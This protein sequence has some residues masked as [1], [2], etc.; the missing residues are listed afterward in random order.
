MTAPSSPPPSST[1]LVF[2]VPGDPEQHTADLSAQAE[3]RLA[4]SEALAE[5]DRAFSKT[6]EIKAIAQNLVNCIPRLLPGADSCALQLYHEDSG[7][8]TSAAVWG[9]SNDDFPPLLLTIDAGIAGRVV[10][11]RQLI[12]CGYEAGSYEGQ[13]YEAGSYEGQGYKAGSYE[14]G[15]V[16][17]VPVVFDGMVLGVLNVFS[18]RPYAFTPDD[19]RLLSRLALRGALALHHAMFYEKERTQRQTLQAISS[20]TALP[21]LDANGAFDRLLAYVLSIGLAASANIMLIQEGVL[22]V[23]HHNGYEGDAHLR[24]LCISVETYYYY[25]MLCSGRPAWVDDVENDPNWYY[26]NG[27]RQMRIRSW[28]AAPISVA[29]RTIGFINIESP[30]PGAFNALIARRLDLMAVYAALAIENMRLHES[31]LATLQAEQQARNGLKE[32]ER[33]VP[34][35][36]MLSTAIHEINNPLQSI[37]N[38]LYILENAADEAA[39]AGKNGIPLP[40]GFQEARPFFDVAISE[41]ERL[42]S[43]VSRL[44][45]VQKSGFAN[46]MRRLTVDLGITVERVRALLSRQLADASIRWT[47]APTRRPPLALADPDQLVQVF[48]NLALNAIDA[49]KADTEANPGK[50]GGEIHIEFLRQGDEI[51][52]RLSDSGPG[53]DA[54]TAQQLFEPYFTTKPGGFGVGLSICSD[55][56]KAHGGRLT[57]ASQPGSGAAFTVWLPTP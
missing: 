46:T 3:R 24:A 5:I 11:R 21:G 25:Q 51:G 52:V 35:G 45:Q 28:A 15:A 2:G 54:Q 12:N 57:L 14:A 6:L 56:V 37:Q 7:L 30:A 40:S 55:I 32:V 49:I 20:I 8:L 18:S 4:E 44:R 33:L 48:L 34:L 13:G 50:V 19:E 22:R 31:L 42:S 41:V 1:H 38:C 43:I 36:R 16:L 53:I 26:P 29:G 17:S 23:T 10:E 39:Q 27:E 47:L 9:L